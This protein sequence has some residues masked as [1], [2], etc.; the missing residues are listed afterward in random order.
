[1]TGSLTRRG[2][3]GAA[4][5]LAACGRKRGPRYQGWLFV[6]SGAGK[7]IAV[8]NLAAFRRI[9]PIPL[10]CAADQL[11][12]AGRKVFAVCRDAQALLEINVERFEVAGRIPIAARPIGARLLPDANTAI[13]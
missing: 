11:F 2:F 1:M 8:A 3:L 13:L 9:S 4:A 7:E 5:A 10:P 6:A 12:R